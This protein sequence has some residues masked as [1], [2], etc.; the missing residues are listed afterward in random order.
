MMG[1]LIPNMSPCSGVTQMAYNSELI[2]NM[3]PCFGVTQIVAYDG[4]EPALS[5][6]LFVRVHIDD[7][8]DNAPQFEQIT[9][10]LSV[11]ENTPPLTTLGT[12]QAS[13]PLVSVI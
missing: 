13:H 3:S 12:I 7:Y 2:P 10:Q 1:E 5:S 4:G 8:N 11:V 6:S 9:Y